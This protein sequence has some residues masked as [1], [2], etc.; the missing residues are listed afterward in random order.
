MKFLIN[1]SKVNFLVS[2]YV[3]TLY[4]DLTTN[5]EHPFIYWVD[6]DG[7]T[8]FTYDKWDN[9]LYIPSELVNDI[10]NLFGLKYTELKP[11]LLDVFNQK[12]NLNL[13]KVRPI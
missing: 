12:F 4:S 9:D 7:E 5:D 10:V 6:T 13:D 8:I 11:I 2:N 3:D 1:E